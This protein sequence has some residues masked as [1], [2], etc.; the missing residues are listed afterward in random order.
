MANHNDK[1]LFRLMF[2]AQWI[3]AEVAMW[4]TSKSGLQNW[5]FEFDYVKGYRVISPWF[6]FALNLCF[7]EARQ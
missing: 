3:W 4:K 5:K 6:G 2:V 1:Y 7:G